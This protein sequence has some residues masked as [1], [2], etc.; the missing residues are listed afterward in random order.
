M[1]EHFNKI[2]LTII[3]KNKNVE[4]II[5][6]SINNNK[7]I[8]ALFYQKNFKNSLKD[9]LGVL[10]TKKLKDIYQ[11]YYSLN[12]FEAFKKIVSLNNFKNNI[13]VTISQKN[14]IE[15]SKF[16]YQRLKL[17]LKM[18]FN[19]ERIRYGNFQDKI[20]NLYD[21]ITNGLK[22]DFDDYGYEDYMKNYDGKGFY[23]FK[24]ALIK[25]KSKLPDDI[26]SLEISS[27]IN[28]LIIDI[29]LTKVKEKLINTSL[30][31][32]SKSIYPNFSDI[33]EKINSNFTNNFI[34]NDS[35]LKNIIVV[36]IIILIILVIILYRYSNTKKKNLSKKNLD[37]ELDFLD[38][39]NQNV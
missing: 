28:K 20:K 30:I 38:N 33:K 8:K 1:N 16:I 5:N 14:G 12:I 18:I 3:Y 10:N 29:F 13:L 19:K 11:Y 27:K 9:I 24:N 6:N 31:K 25:S 4:N 36:I 39:Q 23:N 15:P 22:K 17:D 26:I 2:P 32:I 7:N 34:D 21:S 37:T 35:I